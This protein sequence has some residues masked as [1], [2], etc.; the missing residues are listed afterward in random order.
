M[1]PGEVVPGD[2]PVPR[3]AARRRG[4]V[5]IRNAGR[6]PAYL[7]SHFPLALAS[8]A[9]RFSRDGLDGARPDLPA[10]ASVRIDPGAEVEV[11]VAWS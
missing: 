4:S 5:R 8:S 1:R 10:G 2:G 7:G 3:A 9:L 11:P 6:F